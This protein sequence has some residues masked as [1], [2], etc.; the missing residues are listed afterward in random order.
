MRDATNTPLRILDDEGAEHEY[1]V[2]KHGALE[3]IRL[4]GVI[5]QAAQQDMLDQV[6]D[7][8]FGEKN[9]VEPKD[10]IDEAISTTAARLVAMGP[11]SVDIV[12]QLLFHS[13]RD[14]KAL[15][16]GQI[17]IVY[18]GN[19]G[20]LVRA[21]ELV[22]KEN[23]RGF[24][25]MRVAPMRAWG[26][27][28]AKEFASAFQALTEF[29]SKALGRTGLSGKPGSDSEPEKETESPSLNSKGTGH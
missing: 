19:Y 17:T 12:T 3:G 10:P 2:T 22:I 8:A 13:T 18:S 23:F 4:Y 25:A 24:F 9:K 15:N 1:R 7:A 11:E 29:G 14:D 5:Q 26:E 28:L 16:K 27:R 6:L 21:L 20:E